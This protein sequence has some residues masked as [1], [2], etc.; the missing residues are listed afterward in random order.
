[1]W[2]RFIHKVLGSIFY[3]VKHWNLFPSRPSLQGQP[4][5]ILMV[6]VAGVGD[7]LLCTPVIQALRN[8]FPES[9]IAFMAHKRRQDV[10]R[11]NRFLDELI[12]YQKGLVSFFR[13]AIQL[14]KK[15][16]DHVLV[17]HSTYGDLLP[18]CY[19]MGA[20]H[21][22]GFEENSP[23]DFHFTKMIVHDFKIHTVNDRFRLARPIGA[24]DGGFPM[25]WHIMP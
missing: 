22:I 5:R 17:F 16:F 6:C 21:I 19:M 3:Y 18:L 10:L 12:P 15:Q 1:M 9:H 20:R 25:D 14:R 7:H 24:K 11:H 8:S 23:M 4:R 2:V 13:L